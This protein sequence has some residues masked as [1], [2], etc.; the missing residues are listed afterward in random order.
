M[1]VVAH[2]VTGQNGEYAFE[3]RTGKYSVYLKTDWRNEFQVGVISV[4]EDSQ[5]GTLNDFLIAVSD[6]DLKPDVLRRFDELARR[7]HEDANSA[8][9]FA[10]DARRAVDELGGKVQD[11]IRDRTPD[12]LALPGAYGFGGIFSRSEALSFQG[13]LILVRGYRKP[14]RALSGH[15]CGFFCIA[16][17][18]HEI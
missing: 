9:Q 17:G 14:R 1:S 4:Y 18:H 8:E 12:R 3:A 2:I 13:Y 6:A 5:P 10:G 15:C 7:V 11:D 16:V